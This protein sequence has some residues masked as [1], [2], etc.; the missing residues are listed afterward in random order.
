ML[1]NLFRSIIKT[2][3]RI[4]NNRVLSYK[5]TKP[6]IKVTDCA[7]NKINSILSINKNKAMLLNIS[8]GGCGGFNYIFNIISDPNN[9]HAVDKYSI[10]IS[11]KNINNKI[12]IDSM[13][14][15]YILG[16]T[17]DYIKEDYNNNIFENKFL[18]IPD[19][20]LATNC[21]SGISFSLK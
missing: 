16:T 14:E 12:Y 8:S 21:G 10:I 13:A 4:K 11:P 19:K 6:I 9:N 20:S 17:I 15:F 5:T 18:F 1:I 3:I 7:W 2:N